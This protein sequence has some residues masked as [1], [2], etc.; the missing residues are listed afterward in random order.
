MYEV[1]LK[2]GTQAVAG[3]DN[4]TRWSEVRGT[5]IGLEGHYDLL[6][7]DTRCTVRYSDKTR[8]AIGWATDGA[9]MER[10]FLVEGYLENGDDYSTLLFDLEQAEAVADSLTVGTVY[11]LTL[12]SY[13]L[14]AVYTG[15]WD[16]DR[17]NITIDPDYLVVYHL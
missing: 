4:L 15:G 1:T 6:G 11:D 12:E 16:R 3:F 8:T 13:D 10:P 7:Y 14:H 2:V 5:V 9:T 17:T